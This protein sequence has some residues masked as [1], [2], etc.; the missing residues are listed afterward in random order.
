MAVVLLHP[1]KVTSITSSQTISTIIY[2]FGDPTVNTP[3]VAFADS[4]ATQYATPALCGL[5]YS[6]IDPT[7]A[8]NFGVALSGMQITAWTNN[9]ALIG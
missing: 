6:I 2:P 8:T 7:S 4:V 9:N 1:C 3:Y 5:V